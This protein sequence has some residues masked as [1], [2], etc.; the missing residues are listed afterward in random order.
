[1]SVIIKL[2]ACIL[3][4]QFIERIYMLHDRK[5]SIQLVNAA[6]RIKNARNFQKLRVEEAEAD[7]KIKRIEQA[8]DSPPAI[9]MTSHVSTTM[10][11]TDYEPRQALTTD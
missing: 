8:T 4:G 9:A 2:L 10:L 1:M 11:L 7:Y 6:Q 5:K 3:S